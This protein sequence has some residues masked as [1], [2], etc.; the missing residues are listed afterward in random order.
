MKDLAETTAEGRLRLHF[1]P[2]Q[3]RAWESDRRF[4]VVLAGTQGGKTSFGPYWLWREMQR[5]GPGDYMVV[6]PTYPLLIKKALPEFLRLF[7]RHLRLGSRRDES[8]YNTQQKVY[9]LSADGQARTHGAASPDTPTKVFFG[10]ASDPESLESA[11][12]KAVWL[13]EAGQRKFRL[14]SWEALQR[15][16]SI[17]QGRALVTTTPYDLGWLKQKLWDPWN[18]AGGRT[19]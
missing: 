13:D 8:G 9:A 3:A 18:A 5:R 1:H 2:G 6:T 4:V 14:D 19:R 7:D 15:R 11:T 17:H 12:A 10:H 16:L